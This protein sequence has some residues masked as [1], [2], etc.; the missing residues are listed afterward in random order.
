VHRRSALIFVAC[1]PTRSS[2]C[3]FIAHMSHSVLK[4]AH[5]KSPLDDKYAYVYDH[6]SSTLPEG[7]SR[8]ASH[9]GRVSHAADLYIFL[10]KVVGKAWPGPEKASMDMQTAPV[11]AHY[12][13]A[14]KKDMS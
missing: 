13:C 6:S 10:G 1:F 7:A 2:E 4:P 11:F 3:E 8:S 12:V 14:L 9:P 5:G